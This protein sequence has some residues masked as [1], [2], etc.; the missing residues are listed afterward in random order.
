A[1]LVDLDPRKIGQE[2]HGAQVWSPAEFGGR[3]AR[4]RPFVLGAVGSPGA[5]EEIRT[6]LEELG[7]REL[8]DFRFCA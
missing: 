2:I 3:T 6:A 4:K 1:G 8:R 7:L 5:R